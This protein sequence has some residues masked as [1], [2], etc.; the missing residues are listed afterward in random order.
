[1]NV[2]RPYRRQAAGFSLTELLVV[3]GVIALMAGIIVPTALSRR[4]LS[5]ANMRT[6]SRELYALLAATKVYAATHNVPTAV[7]YGIREM[8]D[9][10]L[11]KRIQ[12]ID[13]VAVVR[14]FKDPDE[15]AALQRDLGVAGKAAADY[16]RPITHEQGNFNRLSNNVALLPL[17]YDEPDW[18]FDEHEMSIS[19][20]ETGFVP[21]RLT[22]VEEG[23]VVVFDPNHDFNGARSFPGLAFPA[24]VFLPSGIMRKPAE[25]S[26]RLKLHVGPMPDEALSLRFET[27]DGAVNTGRPRFMQLFLFPSTGRV[28]IAERDAR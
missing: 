13:S 24:H 11:G 1:M 10:H 27:T 20:K 2:S 28:A 22:R 17:V 12:V 5:T 23:G 15:V 9:S 4:N 18:V 8:G 25:A 21:V 7:V 6:A 16:F 19:A 3:L 26:E 14:G